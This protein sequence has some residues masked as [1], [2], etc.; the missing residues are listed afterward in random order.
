MCIGSRGVDRRPNVPPAPH[1]RASGRWGCRALR[2]GAAVALDN[3]AVRRELPRLAG[4]TAKQLRDRRGPIHAVP[5]EELPAPY[6][7]AG[8]GE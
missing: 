7:A 6:A 8:G 1:L 5:A 2:E 4:D 3:P